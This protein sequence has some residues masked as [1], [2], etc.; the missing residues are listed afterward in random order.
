MI[1]PGTP[2]EKLLSSGRLELPSVE[3][4][5]SELRIIVAESNPTHSIF[6]A[7]HA[8]NYLPIG[9]RLPRDRADILNQIDAALAGEAPVRSEWFRGL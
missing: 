8:S 6:R 1:V 2:I 4:L 7:N 3:G 9:G 5:L